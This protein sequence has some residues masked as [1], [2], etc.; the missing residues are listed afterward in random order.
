MP[1][2]RSELTHPT[3][4]AGQAQWADTLAEKIAYR[5]KMV[6]DLNRLQHEIADL[7]LV[8]MVRGVPKDDTSPR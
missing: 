3:K 7:E 2:K 5:N 8:M 1:S 6:E 4:V